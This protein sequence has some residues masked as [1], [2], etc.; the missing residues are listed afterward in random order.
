LSETSSKDGVESISAKRSSRALIWK[1]TLMSYLNLS[2][3]N[4]TRILNTRNLTD[5]WSL[6][7][8][9]F[10]SSLK[11]VLLFM[12][13]AYRVALSPL[14][15]GACRFEPSCSEYAILSLRSHPPTLALKL[16]VKRLLK[17]RPGGPF[18]FDP[19]PTCDHK[20]CQYE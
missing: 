4:S 19:V 7:L 10:D 14:F 15:G 16:I 8:N 2:V 12:V 9:T 20:G 6:V 18:G 3:R 11:Y 13:I 1:W 17:C 5:L